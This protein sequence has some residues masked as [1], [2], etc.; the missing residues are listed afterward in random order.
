MV[1]ECRMDVR[2]A[3]TSSSLLQLLATRTL[4]TLHTAH[5]TV[6]TSHSA[7]RQCTV[8]VHRTQCTMHIAQCKLRIANITPTA[9]FQSEHCKLHTAQCTCCI[10][11]IASIARCTSH[12]ITNT[13]QYTYPT[14]AQCTQHSESK[15]LHTTPKASLP[16]ASLRSNDPFLFSRLIFNPNT[17]YRHH[18]HYFKSL[19]SSGF[20]ATICF[21]SIH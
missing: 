21:S 3:A 18:A 19:S 7:Q 1:S 15:T 4:Q 6:Q 2:T 10:M 16:L 9:H 8:I 20:F 14:Q 13:A 12:C 5:C 11:C 17:R